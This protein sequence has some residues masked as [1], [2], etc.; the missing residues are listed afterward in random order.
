VNA[1]DA[2]M[3]GFMVLCVIYHV[4][5]TVR[6]K[7]VPKMEVVIHV[8]I[9]TLETIVKINVIVLVLADASKRRGFVILVIIPLM[10][11]IVN[12]RVKDVEI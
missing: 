8:K 12:I 4:V 3:R 9:I 11:I 2:L 10:E 5:Q 7:N 1:L 6:N